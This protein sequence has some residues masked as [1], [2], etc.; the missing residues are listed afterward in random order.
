MRL[1]TCISSMA[2][3]E[4]GEKSTQP[5]DKPRNLFAHA[6]IKGTRASPILVE[7]LNVCV[8]AG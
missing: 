5:V 2:G 4:K 3:L 7:L 6:I 8:Y 1:M